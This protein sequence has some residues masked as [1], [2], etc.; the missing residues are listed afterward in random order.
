[1]KNT[2]LK[3][4]FLPHTFHHK[5]ALPINEIGFTSYAI[6]FFLIAVSFSSIQK[7]N[8]AILGF[9]TNITVT[10]VISQ[11][12]EQ[13]V[14]YGQG[15]VQ[16]STLLSKAAEQKARDMFDKNYWAHFGPNGEKPWDFM[17]RNGYTYVTAGENLA[18]DFNDSNAV[19]TAWMNS[20]THRDNLL[21]G[22]YQDIGVAVVN[23][24]LLGKETTLVVQMFGRP[25]RQAAQLPQGP[26]ANIN[27]N[28]VEAATSAPKKVDAETT[29]SKAP[30]TSLA[31][32]PNP[33]VSYVIASQLSQAL[34]PNPGPSA[35]ATLGNSNPRAMF[36]NVTLALLLFIT[37]LL[38]FDTI[39]VRRRGVSRIATHSIAHI[40]IIIVL[41]AA[42]LLAKAGSIL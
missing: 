39:I 30:E 10:D 36:K 28:R 26:S 31:N 29:A 3:H 11:T 1:M 37:I 18:R 24:T 42:L 7:T 5:K 41:M 32:S 22:S 27:V 15:T 34:T 20:Q 25:Y 35:V 4:L 6:L 8:P 14:K 21:N 23:G 40:S 13:R 33:P 38:V 19:V 12:N 2:R 17:Q 9:A 16:Y